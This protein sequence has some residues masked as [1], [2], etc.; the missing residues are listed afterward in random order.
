MSFAEKLKKKVIKIEPP[1][2]NKLPFEVHLDK[3]TIMTKDRDYMQVIRLTGASFESADD[4]QLNIL[5]KRLNSLFKNISSHNVA[6]WQH[7]IRR[8]E[9]KYPPGEFPEGFAKDLNEKYSSRLSGEKLRVNELYLTVIYR[10]FPSIF[11]NTVFKLVSSADK[12]TREAE[13]LQAVEVLNKVVRQIMRSLRRYDAE[14]LGIYKYQGIYCSEPMELMSFLLNGR[15]QRVALAQAPLRKLVA[16]TRPFFGNET[17]EVRSATGTF[18]GALLG[19][20]LIPTETSSVFLNEL[21]N[22]AV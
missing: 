4:E 15:W 3:H 19:I 8:R 18:Y 10:P 7:I 14:K 21:L 9:T 13:R 11:S 16:A 6:L 2:S 5:H 1:V 20:G 22:R 17:V 12:A